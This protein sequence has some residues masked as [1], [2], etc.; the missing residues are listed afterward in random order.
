M[1][2]FD[3]VLGLLFIAGLTGGY[4]QGLI[5]QALSLGAVAC[6]IILATYLYLP[7][8]AFLAI[9]YPDS[10]ALTRETAAL[11]LTLIA[12]ITALEIAQRKAVAETRILAIGL[13]DQIAGAL[14]AVVA[15]GLQ[16]SIGILILKYLVTLSWPIGGTF[17]LLLTRGMQS[18]T[19]APAL[20]NLLVALVTVV[21]ALL[22]KGKPKF[23]T[24]M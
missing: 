12:L 11:M 5:R 1:N 21:G 16:I 18:S 10:S 17:R 13:L 8:A 14:V 3:V 4:F 6:G 2:W 23:I 7:L 20:Y 24:F 9:M 19:L 22:P 15:V